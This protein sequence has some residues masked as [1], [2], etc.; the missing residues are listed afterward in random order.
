MEV[1][2]TGSNEKGLVIL[3]LGVMVMLNAVLS[4]LLTIGSD[5]RSK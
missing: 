2:V 3:V 4:V 5:M 1:A